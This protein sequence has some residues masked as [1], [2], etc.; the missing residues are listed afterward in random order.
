VIEEDL[1]DHT[2]LIPLAIQLCC[3]LLDGIAVRQYLDEL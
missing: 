3:V 2:S 1:R